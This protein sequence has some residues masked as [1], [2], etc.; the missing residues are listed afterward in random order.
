MNSVLSLL[1]L[2]PKHRVSLGHPSALLELT[3]A[4]G[5]LFPSPGLGAQAVTVPWISQEETERCSWQRCL[6][7]L[8]GVGRNL[9]VISGQE[10]Q[11]R[12]RH[13]TQA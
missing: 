8:G 2:R 10:G 7:S 3:L 13:S 4:L 5:A 12:R 1:S 6:G 11:I 9:G